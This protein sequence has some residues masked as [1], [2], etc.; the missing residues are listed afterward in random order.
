MSVESAFHLLL[1]FCQSHTKNAD[2][3]LVLF[4]VLIIGLPLVIVVVSFVCY[5]WRSVP[6]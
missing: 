6:A 3:A 5:A 4:Y 2:E 1:H